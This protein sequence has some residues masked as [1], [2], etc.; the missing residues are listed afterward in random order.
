MKKI[1]VQSVEQRLKEIDELIMN[2]SASGCE[3]I[4]HGAPV[5]EIDVDVE[6]L[7]KLY[8]RR[9]VIIW[10]LKKIGISEKEAYA[11]L[12]NCQDGVVLP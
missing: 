2:V 7:H 3:K 6:F 11:H 1:N 4:R 8:D 5:S 10:E 9:D 12:R